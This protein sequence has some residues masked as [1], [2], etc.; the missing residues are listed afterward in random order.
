MQDPAVCVDGRCA[1]EYDDD[2]EVPEW[3]EWQEEDEIEEISTD[4]PLTEDVLEEGPFKAIKKGFNKITG[5][6]DKIIDVFGKFYIVA[7]DL[8]GGNLRFIDK[9]G[10]GKT[11]V[12]YFDTI[13]AAKTTAKNAS[14]T[15][16]CKAVIRG[17]TKSPVGDADGFTTK[18]TG[19]KATTTA[20][21]YV[22]VSGKETL[23]NTAK[24]IKSYANVMKTRGATPGDEPPTE[25]TETGTGEGAGEG[26][27]G[28][29]AGETAGTAGT[30]TG[31]T[32][33]GEAAGAAGATDGAKPKRD[34]SS[35]NI[36]KVLKNTFKDVY[37]NLSKEDKQKLVKAILTA[38]G[39]G[40]AK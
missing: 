9:E 25:S 37:T 14:N 40:G 18:G 22:Y 15:A 28:G 13:D 38:A 30:D 19:E 16:K 32:A 33:G 29:G 39:N 26:E 6:F 1:P 27:T 4:E 5:K 10:N 11:S 31:A 2:L 8:N 36:A 24:L 20:P 21:L 7:S 17:V 23:D 3:P 12:D 35:L 34:M